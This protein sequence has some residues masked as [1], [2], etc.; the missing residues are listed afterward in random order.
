MQS[1]YIKFDNIFVYNLRSLSTTEHLYRNKLPFK[2]RNKMKP[3]DWLK[4]GSKRK[5]D[6]RSKHQTQP[7]QLTEKY[8]KENKTTSQTLYV[9]M[10]D[11]SGEVTSQL[12]TVGTSTKKSLG[13]RVKI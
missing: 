6:T 4:D 13:E 5:D 7:K 12:R 1:F 8:N 9:F 11:Q 10:V 2:T 3:G